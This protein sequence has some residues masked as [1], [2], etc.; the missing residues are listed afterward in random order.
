MNGDDEEDQLVAY[1]DGELDENARRA[2]EA[3][4]AVDADLR[5]RLHR[6]QQ[7]GRP[8]APAF[9]ALLEEAPVQR[10]QANL[11]ALVEAAPGRDA[12]PRHRLATPAARFAAAIGVLLFCLGL[13]IG[14]YAPLGFA[15]LPEVAQ[16]AG[17]QDEDWRQA[18]AEYMALYTRDTFATESA[19]QEKELAA[20]GARLG[21]ALTPER[22][23][24]TDLQFK[25]A[26]ILNFQGAP[27]GQLGYVDPSTGPVLFCIIRDSEPDAA[28]KAEKR[29]DYSVASWARA[30]RGYMLI[31]RLPADQTAELANALEKRF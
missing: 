30:G 12:P 19:S 21:L 26:M 10:L 13:A 29:G 27:L 16:P 14:R 28:L 17:D 5:S 6:L 7:G 31:G 3:R 11:A 8:F 15:R 1:I 18:V 22:V 20:L 2:L 4:L 9:R 25:G 23:T 24:L